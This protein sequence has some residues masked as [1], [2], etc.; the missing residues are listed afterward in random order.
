[1]HKPKEDIVG[2][3][4]LLRL[5]IGHDHAKVVRVRCLYPPS[6]CDSSTCARGWE[7]SGNSRYRRSVPVDWYEAFSGLWQFPESQ[8]VA[9][10]IFPFPEEGKYLT[11]RFA[12][13]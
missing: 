9:K 12:A 2:M 11:W 8:G 10:S 6:V 5:P 1:M 7:R 3:V 13:S 4:Q